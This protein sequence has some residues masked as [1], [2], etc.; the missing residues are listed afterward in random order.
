MPRR[1]HPPIKTPW[2]NA[3]LSTKDYPRLHVKPYKFKYVH[4]VAFEAIA[5]RPV[6]DGFDIH[7]QG[8]KLCWCGSNL[9]EIEKC[10]HPVVSGHR[11]CPYTGRFLNKA[12]WQRRFGD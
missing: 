5:G 7:H 4:R 8:S 3:H 11:Q 6:R 9:I 10:L 2:G 12:E 1:K